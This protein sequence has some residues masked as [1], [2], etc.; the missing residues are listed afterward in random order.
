MM[1]IKSHSTM[2]I[3][4]AIAVVIVSGV[5]VPVISDAIANG[6]G[7]GNG[8]GGSNP[9]YTNTGDMYY[10]IPDGQ[11]H[12]I[13]ID[14]TGTSMQFKFDGTLLFEKPMGEEDRWMIPLH[15]NL[16]EGTVFTHYLIWGISNVNMGLLP[17]D[18]VITMAYA[19]GNTEL[20]MAD[21]Y[22]NIAI[23]N[24][25]TIKTNYEN[26]SDSI[27]YLY[28]GDE[29]HPYTIN[30]VQWY[31][32]NS[33]EYV[34]SATPTV[35]DDT[36]LT[37][38]YYECSISD[39][40]QQYVCMCGQSTLTQ[41]TDDHDIG[42]NG[43]KYDITAD[44]DDFISDL[45]V[46]VNSTSLTDATKIN[47]MVVAATWENYDDSSITYSANYTIAG[48]VVPVTVTKTDA[49]PEYGYWTEVED[50]EWDLYVKYISA[51]EKVG[52]YFTDPNQNDAEPFFTV[53]MDETTRNPFPVMIGEDFYVACE[54]IPDRDFFPNLTV[55]GDDN[56][57]IPTRHIHINGDVITYKELYGD[58]TE[59][60]TVGLL[61]NLSDHGDNTAYAGNKDAPSVLYSAVV[62]EGDWANG[63]EYYTA[64]LVA[65]SD[66]SEIL[67]SDGYLSIERNGVYSNG[68]WSYATATSSYV[69]ENGKYTGVNIKGTY[70]SIYDLDKDFAFGVTDT[71]SDTD[72]EYSFA[73]A[74]GP[75]DNGGGSGGG[76]G[77]IPTSLAAI[78]S[79]VP[80]V[81][82]AGLLFMGLKAFRM[83]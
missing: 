70:D 12:I 35:M 54:Y 57:S 42:C 29:E 5:M 1:D 14:Y 9:T 58:D 53:A 48:F 34:Y 26:V 22:D 63:E 82:L 21:Y 6:N 68:D 20:H 13:A 60:N 40:L 31:L 7:G 39:T 36:V 79:A 78:L 67:D 83:Q 51:E 80:I 69:V 75:I 55:F 52:F 77:S 72:Y 27:A 8:G 16:V 65:L 50:K 38:A 2:I 74:I 41:I 33:G 59:L 62:Y 46:N 10:Q 71:E 25:F 56:T 28:G 37:F 73:F 76:G 3:A 30:N 23:G 81:V 17:N 45:T 61:A 66:D 32:A 18:H 19:E 47:S 24:F 49:P 44:T 4:L 11:E 64:W 43:Y 15:Q